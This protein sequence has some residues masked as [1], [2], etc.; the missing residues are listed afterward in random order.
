[1]SSKWEAAV[2]Y[3]NKQ[4]ADPNTANIWAS[5]AVL[6]IWKYTKS[7]LIHRNQ[8][9]HGRNGEETAARLLHELHEEVKHLYE[10]FEANPAFLL[11]R[12]HYLFT[13][14][15]L[16]QRLRTPYDN[17]T[18][19]LC[20]VEE[21]QQALILHESILHNISS[22]FF[23]RPHIN[24][25]DSSDDTYVPSSTSGSTS[26]FTSLSNTASTAFLT[27]LDASSFDSFSLDSST[28][29]PFSC[30]DKSSSSDTSHSGAGNPP[31]PPP[32]LV[33]ALVSLLCL[34]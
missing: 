7:L 31:P 24:D 6:L 13:N 18:C 14:R 21:A 11:P 32:S 22:R 8:I 9:V 5:Q 19:L 15:S 30:T 29:S 4:H 25:Y 3:Y 23:S 12:H 10:T 26:H 34:K 20:S 17:I 2:R 1:M 27:T 28:T 33:G 16:D